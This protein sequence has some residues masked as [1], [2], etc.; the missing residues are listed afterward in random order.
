MENLHARSRTWNFCINMPV[1]LTPEFVVVTE[2]KISQSF[3]ELFE[4]FIV[5]LFEEP[6]KIHDEHSDEQWLSYA[7]REVFGI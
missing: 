6:A 2:E 4:V 1:L 3:F 7:G 5:F